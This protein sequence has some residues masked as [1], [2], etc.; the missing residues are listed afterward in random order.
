MLLH[1][2]QV[3]QKLAPSTT[4]CIRSRQHPKSSGTAK[5]QSQMDDQQCC[6]FVQGRCKQ[7]SA[8]AF[9]VALDLERAATGRDLKGEDT[10]DLQRCHCLPGGWCLQRPSVDG[11][12]NSP[13]ASSFSSPRGCPPGCAT[14]R[15]MLFCH[16]SLA[17]SVGIWQCQACCEA[18]LK[19][20]ASLLHCAA[21]LQL[22]ACCRFGLRG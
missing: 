9:K 6:A 21:C 10:S 7:A 20:V 18:Q 8:S 17:Y 22:P 19:A 2:D 15:P 16:W 3:L 4:Y 5:A 12:L 1:S 11:L 13:T 14:E